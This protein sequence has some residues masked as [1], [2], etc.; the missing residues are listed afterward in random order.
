[1]TS[2]AELQSQFRSF[3]LGRDRSIEQLTVGTDNLPA[4][5]RLAV[6]GDAYYLRLL[7]ALEEDFPGLKGLVDERE[8]EALG[9]AY[10][11]A[12]PSTNPSVRWFGRHL[13][14]FLRDADGY[15][16]RPELAEMAAFEWTQGEVM[17]AADSSAV[18]MEEFGSLPG[19]SWPAMRF[20]FQDALRR[21]DL[22]WNV[23]GV[24]QAIREQEGEAPPPLERS[25]P[26]V[27]WLF[28]RQNLEVHWRSIDDDECYALDAA[29]GDAAFGEICEGLLERTHDNQ[30]PLRAAGYLKRWLTDGLIARIR[31]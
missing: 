9:R 19:E 6:Y 25:E 22:E 1:M 13:P 15:R 8:F 21:L 29:R 5:E 7:E 17:D 28:W 23:P 12:Y 10:I 26:P 30:V 11:D 18:D 2:L 4:G 16:D 27:S 3:L 20:E 31:T 14:R 24:R